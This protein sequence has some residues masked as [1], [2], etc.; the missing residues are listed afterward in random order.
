MEV[1]T[2]AEFVGFVCFAP[3]CVAGPFLEYRHFID[4]LNLEGDYADM[5]RG[6]SLPTLL[7]TVLTTLRAYLYFA[8]M[9]F[10]KD[11]LGYDTSICGEADWAARTTFLQ[12]FIHYNVALTGIR[13][14]YY[15][16]FTFQEA[17]LVSCGL[18]W[19][20][21]KDGSQNWDKLPGIL[22]KE[23]EFSQS[24][25]DLV[26][27]WNHQV[28]LWLKRYVHERL[29]GPGQ[30]PTP[31]DTIIV[32][33]VSALWHGFYP[34]YFIMMFYCGL[35]TEVAR[36]VYKSR[37]LFKWIPYPINYILPWSLSMLVANYVGIS[38]VLFQMDLGLNYSR[39]T[40]FWV[41]IALPVVCFGIKMSGMVEYAKSLKE[42]DKS[43]GK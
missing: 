35:L 20:G 42:A 31:M 41:W 34:F 28:H 32:F 37:D 18:S 2:L 16:V 17:N 6:L 19:N 9:V 39:A 8:I 5:P 26:R 23:V 29:V 11:Y 38:F 15:S 12:R 40:Y 30:R 33:L 22:I 43:N 21:Y 14:R 36:D 24:P 10:F 13:W 1:P 27:G 3:G 7:P 4:W 25:L